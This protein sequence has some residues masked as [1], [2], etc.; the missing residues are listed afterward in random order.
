VVKKTITTVPI[1]NAFERRDGCPLCFLWTNTES[2]YIEHVESNEMGMDPDF[3]VKIL[4][5]AGFCNR[6]M[7]LLFEA[8]FSGHTENGLGYA[9]FM[10]DVVNQLEGRMTRMQSALRAAGHIMESAKFITRGTA[11]R[12]QVGRVIDELE[13][14]IQGSSICPICDMLLDFDARTVSTFLEMLEDKDFADLFEA[15]N[16]ICLPHFVSSME[17]LPQKTAKSKAVGNLLF[18]VEIRLSRKIKD[19][20]DGRI[21]K[22]AW[23]HRDEVLS[24]EEAGSQRAALLT[25]A[26]AEGLYCRP[27]K[28]SLRTSLG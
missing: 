23:D 9:M 25:I 13:D 14:S 28:A 2:S 22:Y 20:L 7:H 5:S 24:P 3:R 10:R 21:R 18:V 26:G 8:A 12:R 4:A 1:L 16:G 11:W 27:R 17:L 6:H 19:L 15:S